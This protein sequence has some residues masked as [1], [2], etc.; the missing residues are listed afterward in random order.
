MTWI[1]PVLK[2]SAQGT[3]SDTIVIPVIYATWYDLIGWP[4]RLTSS[5]DL[6]WLTSSVD[7]VGWPPLVVPLAAHV[8]EF[9]QSRR[10]SALGLLHPPGRC[11]HPPRP[12]RS[13]QPR[14]QRQQGGR[15][16]LLLLLL[17]LLLWKLELTQYH[18]LFDTS[19]CQNCVRRSILDTLRV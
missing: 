7:L 11:V 4:R 8:G 9:W 17:L 6:I 15:V 18:N 16:V 19:R 2:F 14:L 5:V 12:H 13:Q 3:Y 10:S 1:A